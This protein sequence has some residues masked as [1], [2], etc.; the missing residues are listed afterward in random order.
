MRPTI[1]RNR[2]PE[3]HTGRLDWAGTLADF[4]AAPAPVGA[5]SAS[6]SA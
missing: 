1:S 6:A 4:A 5:R 3:K 2:A